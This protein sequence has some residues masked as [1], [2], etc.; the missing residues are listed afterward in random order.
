MAAA[1]GCPGLEV[2][3]AHPISWV[4]S[5]PVACDP[6]A[7]TCGAQT[8]AGCLS[9][10]TSLLH[11]PLP[12]VGV[13]IGMEWGVASKMTEL[14]PAAAGCLSTLRSEGR[15]KR[16]ALPPAGGGWGPSGSGIIVFNLNYRAFFKGLS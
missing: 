9:R 7:S 2:W 6:S 13:S 5:R 1:A 12:L 16:C 3:T 14:S 15:K 10:A 4:F 11:L 8:A